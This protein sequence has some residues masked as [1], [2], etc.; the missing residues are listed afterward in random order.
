M[1]VRRVLLVYR[2][3]DRILVNILHI[4]KLIRSRVAIIYS[5]YIAIILF[6]C[7]SINCFVLSFYKNIIFTDCIYIDPR[8]Y[9]CIFIFMYLFVLFIV[10]IRLKNNKILNSLRADLTGL[11][12]ILILM[13]GMGFLQFLLLYVSMHNSYNIY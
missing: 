5:L 3:V 12:R 1:R 7:L 11:I 4:Y 8:Q 13:L 6:F 9:V 2:L 10:Y